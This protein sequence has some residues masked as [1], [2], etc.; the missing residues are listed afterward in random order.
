MLCADRAKAPEFSDYLDID[1]L[2]SIRGGLDNPETSV[3]QI[4]NKMQALFEQAANSAL[5]PEIEYEIDTNRKYKPMKFDRETRKIRNKYYRA[6]RANDG[7]DE[8]KKE[9][10]KSSREYKK[11]VSKTKALQGKKIKQKLR[12]NKTRNPK[13]YWSMLSD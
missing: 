10:M 5:G 9:V 13:Y 2:D 7:S 12:N 1:I 8:K 11:A 4:I 3:D 6:K